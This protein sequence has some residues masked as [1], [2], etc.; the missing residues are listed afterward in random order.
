MSVS[1]HQW[2]EYIL[3]ACLL[4]LVCVI[5]AVMAYFYTYIDPTKIEAQF[6]EQE[7]EDKEKRKS[8][9][10]ARKDSVE[11]RKEDSSSS[12]SSSDE[13]EAQTKI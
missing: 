6:V 11:Q 10:M 12:S 1:V 8:L 5:F 7:S 3:F 2:A 4:L 13:E 9:E